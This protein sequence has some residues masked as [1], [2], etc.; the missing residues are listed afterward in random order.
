[1][2]MLVLGTALRLNFKVEAS[3][4]HNDHYAYYGHNSQ[5]PAWA[6]PSGTG[7]AGPP[8]MIMMMGTA[9][10]KH[11]DHPMIADPGGGCQ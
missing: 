7:R 1:M 6:R 11:Y 3:D 4:N 10:V 2:M 8:G 5:G 9:N